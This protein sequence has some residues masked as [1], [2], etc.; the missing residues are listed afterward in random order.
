MA[1]TLIRIRG[2]LTIGEKL[3]Q[4]PWGLVFTIAVTAGIGFAML[5]SAAG[6]NWDPWASRQIIRFGVGMALLIAVSL[7]DIRWWFRIAYVFYGVAL[8]LLVAV[9]EM[10]R[11]GLGAQRWL[12]FGIFQVQPSELMKIAL[13]LVLARYFH[14]VTHQE[15]GNPL[16]LIFPAALVL[17]PI[18]LVFKQ[19]DLGS[20]LLIAMTAAVMFFLAGMRLWK[21]GLLLGGAVAAVP[22]AWTYLRDYQKQRVLTFLDPDIDPLGAGYHITQSKIALGSGGIWGKGF[23]QGTQSHL[24]FLPERQTDFIGTMLLEE[25]GFM[26]GLSL[27]VLYTVILVYGIWIA[28]R[29]KTQFGRLTAMG[30]ITSFYVYAFINLAMVMGLLPVVGEPLP[31]VSYGGTAMMSLLIGFGLLVNVYIH[32]EVLFGRSGAAD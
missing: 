31:L 25:F 32:R 5:Y 30:I 29:V 15:M 8:V 22:V 28:L 10:G 1:T 9:E 12:D 11:I 21:I 13:V 3:V 2:D 7:I 23:L 6:G 4:L 24:Q 27:L 20:T 16:R 14:G 26:G 18:Y 19:P 17:A